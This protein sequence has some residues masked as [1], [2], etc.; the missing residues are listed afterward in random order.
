M[1]IY[2]NDINNSPNGVDHVGQTEPRHKWPLWIGTS[3]RFHRNAHILALG[4]PERGAWL[5]VNAA[6]IKNKKAAPGLLGTADLASQVKMVA[7]VGFEPT[8]FRL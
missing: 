7:G 3:G 1:P 5:D 2:K 8:T 6:A 4:S